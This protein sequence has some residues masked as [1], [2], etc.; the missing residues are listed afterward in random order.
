MDQVGEVNEKIQAA[1][2]DVDESD[3]EHR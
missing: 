2:I 1:R 3:V